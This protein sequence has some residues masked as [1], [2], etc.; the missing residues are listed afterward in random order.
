M[1]RFLVLLV[2]IPIIL[3]IAAFAYRNAGFVKIDLFTAD[4]DIP[5]VA[6]LLIAL[7]VGMIIGF[8]ANFYVVMR[9]KSKIRHL[10]KQRETLG[11]LSDVFKADK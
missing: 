9:Q 7:L 5:L 10:N 2:L 3:I 4:Y 8:L 6:L 1:I 11:R